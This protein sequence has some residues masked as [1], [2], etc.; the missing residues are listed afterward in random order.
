MKKLI[1]RVFAKNFSRFYEKKI[2]LGNIRRLVDESFVPLAQQTS[3]SYCRLTGFESFLPQCICCILYPIAKVVLE[4]YKRNSIQERT[5]FFLTYIMRGNLQTELELLQ[6]R[7]F[8][9]SQQ[10]QFSETNSMSFKSLLKAA[11][12][13]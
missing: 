2:I 6:S 11:I 9:F 4:F 1:E 8:V 12:K 5:P 13:M 3:V 7:I 10:K